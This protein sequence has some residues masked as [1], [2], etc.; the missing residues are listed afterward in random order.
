MMK[1]RPRAVQVEEKVML[2]TNA[3]GI[4]NQGGS[5]IKR[6]HKGQW[7]APERVINTYAHIR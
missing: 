4:Q 6:L 2:G 5:G 3:T 1:K 7:R